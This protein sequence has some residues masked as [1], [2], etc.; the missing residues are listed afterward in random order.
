MINNKR[1]IARALGSIAAFSMYAFLSLPAQADAPG[2]G[3]TAQFE[4]EF[5]TFAINHHF[6][7]LRMTELAAGTDLQRDEAVPNPGEGTAPTPG[8]STTPA[9]ATDEQIKSLARQANRT[10][11]EEIARS[12]RMLLDWYGVNV[13]PQGTPEGKQ[14]IQV[15]EQTAA[16]PQF[17]HAFLEVFS[18]HHHR[19]LAPSLECQVKSDLQ[20]DELKRMCENITVTQKNQINDM[21][22]RLCKLFGN[23]DFQ[24]GG[25]RGRNSTGQ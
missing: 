24:P 15:L 20:H 4:K 14:A 7:A 18:S 25:I 21:R 13:T 22:Q 12:Q 23:C 17:N 5:L 1:H 6:S 10:Q 16:G 2:R 9:K 3:L 19:I 8:A 11:R